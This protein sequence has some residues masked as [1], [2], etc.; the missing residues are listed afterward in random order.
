MKN[1]VW[2]VEVYID[3]EWQPICTEYHPTRTQARNRVWEFN[4]AP[5]FNSVPNYESMRTYN[6]RAMKYV[7]TGEKS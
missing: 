5:Y 3:G 2:V 4:N 1:H 6:Y 7:R